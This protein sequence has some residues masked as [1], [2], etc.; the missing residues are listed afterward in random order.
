M[1]IRAYFDSG[2]IE[3]YCL[4]LL[5]AEAAAGVEQ[6]SRQYPAIDFE[7]R[8]TLETLTRFSTIATPGPQL[9]TK[10]FHLIEQ[11]KTEQIIDLESLPFIHQYS[12]VAAWNK[13]LE[14]LAPNFEEDSARYHFLQERPDFQLAVVWLEGQLVEDGHDPAEFEESFLILEG[15]CECNI[16]EKVIHL[17]AGDY[18]EIPRFTQHTIRNTSV[19][20]Q[21]FVKALVQR[22]KAA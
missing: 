6:L 16:G 2:I 22:R 11:L 21:P 4:G 13:V 5:D 19:H 18:L 15:T 7:I 1:D 12:D 10:L 8:Q 3:E 20:P 14:G 17:K 9:K